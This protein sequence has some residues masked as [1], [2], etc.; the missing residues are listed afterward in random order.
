MGVRLRKACWRVGVQSRC[1]SRVGAGSGCGGREAPPFYPVNKK[2]K[3]DGPLIL[4]RDETG[5][6]IFLS[7][8]YKDLSRKERG[9]CAPVPLACIPC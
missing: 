7:P 8:S 5:P 6:W 9:S 3:M 4:S 2:S 1:G